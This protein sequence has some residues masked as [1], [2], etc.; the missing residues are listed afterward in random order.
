MGASEKRNQSGILLF[1]YS[2]RLYRLPLYEELYR[3]YGV[4]LCHSLERGDKGPS[5]VASQLDTPNELIRRFYFLKK[6][7]SL[8]Q[9]VLPSLLKYRPRIVITSVETTYMTHWL[10]QLLK[11]I[12]GYSLIGWSHGVIN[13]EMMN[14]FGTLN[15]KLRLRIFKML[16]AVV[17]YSKERKEIVERFLGDQTRVFSINNSTDTSD[18]LRYQKQLAEEGM[19]HV[20]SRL[21]YMEQ[22]HLN[23]ISRLHERKRLDILIDAFRLLREKGMDVALHV[24]GAGPMQSWLENEQ[25]N[26]PSI[27]L[28]G[29][30]Y[31]TE[32]KGDHLFAADVSVM[33]GDVGLSLVDSFSFGTPF[34]TLQRGEQGPFHGPEL[35]YLKDSVNGLIVKGGSEELAEELCALLKDPVRLKKMGDEGLRTA[36]E[37]CSID[38]MVEGFGDAIAAVQESARG[39]HA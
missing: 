14:P 10:L 24:I 9:L 37:E 32:E 22:F 26:L 25:K 12:F 17:V 13:S 18:A 33:P 36:R 4:V 29:K 30:L 7:T 21:G 27:Y 3:T 23:F 31:S 20:R 34:V 5:P 8:V 16:D 11:P 15:G 2:Q 6:P 1:E 35:E 39:R 28:H 19:D 38:R